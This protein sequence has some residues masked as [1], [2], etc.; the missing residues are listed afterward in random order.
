MKKDISIFDIAVI[1][2]CHNRKNTTLDCLKSLWGQ[3]YQFN[4][5]LTIYLV[6]DGSSDGTSEAVAAAYPD[7]NIIAGSGNLY[8][9]RG[10]HL[11]FAK[12]I[13]NNHD[14]YLWLN[15]D[16]ILNSTT[17]QT[18]L[19][20]YTRHHHQGEIGPVIVGAFSNHQTNAR[21]SEASEVSYAGITRT[22]S[23]WLP[24]SQRA[25][26]SSHDLEC[27]SF[28]GNGVLIASDVVSKVGNIDPIFHHAMGDMDYGYRCSSQ[29]IKIF[30]CKD[31]I[32]YCSNDVSN[33]KLYTNLAQGNWR[34]LP[35][36]ARLNLMMSPKNFPIKGWLVF[37]FRYL[38]WLWFIR[39]MRPY[40]LAIFPNLIPNHG[41]EDN[42]LM[43]D[44]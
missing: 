20:C 23:R 33:T 36:F 42:S 31:I 25:Y 6:D 34:D 28:L 44:S 43:K 29:S 38:G 37:S 26:S 30:V 41:F 13:Q 39:F 18:L 24:R 1:M 22:D 2:T 40:T 12:A 35:L 16:V 17:I 19:S 15:D 11:G 21:I 4:V 14:F 10:M 7:V 8:W 3:S 27:D 5:E 9:N 32:G